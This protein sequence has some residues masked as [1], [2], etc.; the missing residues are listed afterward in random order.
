MTL[1]SRKVPLNFIV[2][3][4]SVSPSQVG[5][6]E[7]ISQRPGFERFGGGLSEGRGRN[8]PLTVSFY[9]NGR[10]HIETVSPRGWILSSRVV[11]EEG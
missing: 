3:N 11:T 7:N 10:L 8:S 1:E 5:H 2:L 9:Q 4:R 6:L